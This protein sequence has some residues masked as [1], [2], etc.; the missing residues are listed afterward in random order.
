VSPK[1]FNPM[2][3][4][5]RCRQGAAAVEFALL[6]WPFCLLLFGIIE[7][8]VLTFEYQMM[9][10][11]TRAAA[12]QLRTGVVQTSADALTTFTT[13]FCANVVADSCANFTFDVRTF[14]DFPDIVLPP[15]TFNKSGVPTNATFAPGGPGTV[16]TVRVVR[17]YQFLTPFIGNLIGGSS[18]SVQLV[19]TAVFRTEPF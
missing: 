12:R 9:D 5:W 3:R 18:N 15:F 8:G 1:C 7:M 16:V 19:S 2:T 11:A 13:I 14:G 4:L 6:F 17:D 10:G